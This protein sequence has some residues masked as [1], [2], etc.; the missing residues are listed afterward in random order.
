M[1][2]IIRRACGLLYAVCVREYGI[3]ISEASPEG[4]LRS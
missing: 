4:L 3:S 1:T 2:A